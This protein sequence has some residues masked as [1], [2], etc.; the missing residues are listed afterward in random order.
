[1]HKGYRMQTWCLG[2][3]HIPS[4]TCTLLCGNHVHFFY[5][6]TVI[7]RAVI[8]LYTGF[9]SLLLNVPKFYLLTSSIATKMSRL[10]Q[11]EDLRWRK[12]RGTLILSPPSNTNRPLSNQ[13]GHLRNQ[14]KSVS[15]SVSIKPT[16]L[17]VS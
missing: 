13:S 14:W 15:Q 4:S 5:D 16:Y 10:F 8:Y 11:S 6:K 2:N 7:S 1:M 17:F 3:N 12:S 9:Y